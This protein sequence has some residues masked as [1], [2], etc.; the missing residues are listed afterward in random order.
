MIRFR[1]LRLRLTLSL[2]QTFCTDLDSLTL[3][4]DRLQIFA[5]I[6]ST[7]TLVLNR[8]TVP[9]LYWMPDEHFDWQRAGSAQ[10]ASGR[11]AYGCAI[12]PPSPSRVLFPS[13]PVPASPS[14]PTTLSQ[15]LSILTKVSPSDQHRKGPPV[16]A[17]HPRGHLAIG[18]VS[19]PDDDSRARQIQQVDERVRQ[20]ATVALIAP[21]RLTPSGRHPDM[22][23]EGMLQTAVRLL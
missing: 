5:S 21:V 9:V 10:I 19:R 7:L 17:P 12:T 14:T 23:R 13:C 4:V 22:M 8:L 2:S 1:T 15:S 18:G 6:I 3:G 20:R 11:A 16:A